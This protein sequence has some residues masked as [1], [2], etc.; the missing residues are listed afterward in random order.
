MVRR[1][2]RACARDPGTNDSA[3]SAP[4]RC[5]VMVP[6][7]QFQRALDTPLK[8]ITAISFLPRKILISWSDTIRNLERARCHWN[9][10]PSDC[11]ARIATHQYSRGSRP[12]VQSDRST[13]I[14][15]TA[16][17]SAGT[18]HRFAGARKSCGSIPTRRPH[19]G[20][21]SGSLSPRRR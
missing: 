11:I 1:I 9:S 18:N 7:V 3:V 10:D 16:P 13:P 14:A 6:D 15:P 4:G 2:T 8:G 12:F 19:S 5:N 21:R 17:S 20:H